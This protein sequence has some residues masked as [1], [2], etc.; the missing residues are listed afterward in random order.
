MG[1]KFGE[2]RPQLGDT[3][4][5]TY[6]QLQEEELRRPH[7]SCKSGER[8]MSEPPACLSFDSAFFFKRQSLLSANTAPAGVS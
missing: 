1:R 2:V 3:W 5:P 7:C 6:W 8:A 4:I